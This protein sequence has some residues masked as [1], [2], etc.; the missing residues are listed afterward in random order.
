MGSRKDVSCDPRRES[1]SKPQAPAGNEVQTQA[2][3]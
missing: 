1:G 3:D 2:R